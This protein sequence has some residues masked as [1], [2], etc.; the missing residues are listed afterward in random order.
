MQATDEDK[1]LIP[2]FKDPIPCRAVSRM[3]GLLLEPQPSE[4]RNTQDSKEPW[5]HHATRTC[6]T[7][8]GD[9][10]MLYTKFR[11]RAVD[12]LTLV[13]ESLPP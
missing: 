6:P 11:L 3:S 2:A 5:T 12:G 8:E 10:L 13:N 9:G 1:E 4:R 7:A